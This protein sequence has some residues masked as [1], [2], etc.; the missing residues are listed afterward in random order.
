MSLL[1]RLSGREEN[2]IAVHTFM[3]LLAEYKRGAITA[4]QAINAL[5]LSAGEVT[6][7]Q[8]LITRIDAN[9]VDRAM[10]H[11]VLLLLET[12]LYTEILAQNRL[13]GT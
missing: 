10:I 6:Q 13:M 11:D 3:A 9:Q 5:E 7:V 8:A 12:G 2:K 4:Q 1:G